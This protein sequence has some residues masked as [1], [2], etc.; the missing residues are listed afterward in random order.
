LERLVGSVMAASLDNELGP[1]ETPKEFL[2]EM[3]RLSQA[4]YVTYRQLVESP[5]FVPYFRAASPVDVLGKLNIGS[6]PTKRKETKGI[7]DLR[8]IPWVFSW[9]QNRHLISA[10]F[11]VGSAL[12]QA[13]EDPQ[14]LARLRRM[15]AE[16]RFFHNLAMSLKVSLL[17]ADM[18]IAGWYANL[19]P[20]MDSRQWIYR[21]ISQEYQQTVAAV[22]A[23][24]Q[25]NDLGANLPNWTAAS[26][27]R[28]PALRE[29]H[30]IQVELLR[31]AQA[32]AATDTDLAHLLL[33]INCI[34]A[35]LRNTG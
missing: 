11:G 5:G 16:W 23:V 29:M 8:A 13:M 19:V 9:T 10:W 6:R 25:A 28:L 31:R 35:G 27:L 30:R 1:S 22:L 7:E 33:T 18:E 14:R 4:A 2:E 20:D 12:G 26:S 32:G 15:H 3:E 21:S 17:T 24:T 34:T